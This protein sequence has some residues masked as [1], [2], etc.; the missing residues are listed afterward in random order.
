M[1]PDLMQARMEVLAKSDQE[2]EKE[3]D[4]EKEWVWVH[5]ADA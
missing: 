5:Q 3:K 4:Q 1:I 2:K